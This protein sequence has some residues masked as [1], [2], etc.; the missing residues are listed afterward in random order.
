MIND[1]EDLVDDLGD[2]I[3]GSIRKELTNFDNSWLP[4]YEFTLDAP[5]EFVKYVGFN[6]LICQDLEKKI[7]FFTGDELELK[8][9]MPRKFK[10]FDAFGSERFIIVSLDD[11]NIQIFDR[12]NF[13]VVKQMKTKE[14]IMTIT[15]NDDRYFQC[16][17]LDGYRTFFDIH[18]GFKQTSAEKRQHDI[19]CAKASRKFGGEQFGLHAEDEIVTDIGFDKWIKVDQ[20]RESF[21]L[22]SFDEEGFEKVTGIRLKGLDFLTIRQIVASP[23]FGINEDQN[24]HVAIMDDKG[25]VSLI[26][27]ELVHNEFNESLFLSP[28]KPNIKLIDLYGAEDVETIG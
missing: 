5:S 20:Q 4:H 11:Q 17:G 21:Y 23:Y 18:K 26:E 7:Y 28:F 12:S 27:V 13:A 6:M 15:Y 3:I 22:F 24:H 25:A 2:E 19:L 1:F 8:Q 9:K 16:S 10:V 14:Q